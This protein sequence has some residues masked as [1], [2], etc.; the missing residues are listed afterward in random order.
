MWNFNDTLD[1]LTNIFLTLRLENLYRNL[2]IFFYN[3]PKVD[4]NKKIQLS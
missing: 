3:V 2:L 1:K 4:K